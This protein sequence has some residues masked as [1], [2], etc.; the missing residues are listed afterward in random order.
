MERTKAVLLSHELSGRSPEYA[1]KKSISIKPV[2][3]IARGDSCNAMVWS[4]S[5]HAGTHIDAPRHFLANGKPIS[6]LKP[7]DLIFDHVH[8]MTIASIAA[9]Q[10]I[11]CDDL[12]LRGTVETELLLIKTG[13]EKQRAKPIYWKNSPWVDPGIASY[14]KRAYPKLRAVGID[15]ISISNANHRDIGHAAHKEFFKR[16]VCLIEDMKLSVLKRS[17]V[18]VIV[19]PVMVHNADASVCTVWASL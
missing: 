4:F 16:G 13:F 15:C 5:N 12:V 8:V 11:C 9:G 1:G 14:L 17:P 3:S 10:R 2:R 19:S 6:G 18:Q 7:S